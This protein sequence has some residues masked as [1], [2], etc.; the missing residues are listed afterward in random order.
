M[1]QEAD[2]VIRGGLIADGSGGEPFIGD[3]AVSAGVIVAAGP[4]LPA[5]GREE[6]GPRDYQNG[7][8][9]F[10]LDLTRRFHNRLLRQFLRGGDGSV[11]RNLGGSCEKIK[12]IIWQL[13][14]SVFVTAH[15]GDAGAAYCNHTQ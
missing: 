7:E 12:W 13:G 14:V 10:S 2:L 4:S 8:D 5:R 9:W 6:S 1:A 11:E 3:I 15:G